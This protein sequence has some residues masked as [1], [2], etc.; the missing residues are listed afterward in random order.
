MSSGSFVLKRYQAT[1]D[2]SKYH[3][4][5]VQPET[6]ALEI[7]GV[8]NAEP[9]GALNS[10]P[11]AQVSKGKRALGLNARMVSVTFD[12]AGPDG[13]KAQGTIRLPWLAN[14]SFGAIAK[15]QTGT[16]LGQ[17]VTVAGKTPEFAN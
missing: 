9:P 11:S 17:P 16:Y 15:G 4:I 14:A 13:Y 10:Y 12:G 5:R 2:P 7:G 8:T 6:L 1:A 3:P